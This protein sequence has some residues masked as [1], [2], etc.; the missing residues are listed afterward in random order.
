MIME[1]EKFLAGDKPISHHQVRDPEKGGL[2]AREQGAS[3]RFI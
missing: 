1:A 2:K 3:V